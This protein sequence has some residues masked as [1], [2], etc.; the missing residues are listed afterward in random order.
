M[1]FNKM[2][3][4]DLIFALAILSLLFITSGGL[5]DGILGFAAAS[6]IISVA[7]HISHYRTYKKFY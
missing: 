5:L 3:L 6:F 7:N 1:L 4:T 2:I